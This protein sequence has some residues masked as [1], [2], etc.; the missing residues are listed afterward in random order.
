MAQSAALSLTPVDVEPCVPP[1]PLGRWGLQIKNA[2]KDGTTQSETIL[3]SYLDYISTRLQFPGDRHPCV[4]PPTIPSKW[5][6]PPQRLSPFI[7]ESLQSSTEVVIVAAS[8]TPVG[9]LNGVLKTLTAPELGIIALKHALDTSK[10]SPALVEEVYFG[11]VVQAG[12]GQS[13]ARQVALGSGIS[14]SS[15]ATTVNK[16]CASGLKSIILA[17]Q[18]IS[19]GDKSVVVAGGMESM[20]N[21]PYV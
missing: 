5:S 13:P 9:S 3:G 4:L 17:S 21:A 16:V 6:V 14:S 15:D 7:N 20:S 1:D 8:R 11:N 19:T 10:I 18:T 2:I 12:V